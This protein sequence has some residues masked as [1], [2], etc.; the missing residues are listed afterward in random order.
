MIN[1]WESQIQEIEKI[2]SFESSDT[3]K[4]SNLSLD[5]VKSLSLRYI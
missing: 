1:F 3:N 5:I 2:I 4:I